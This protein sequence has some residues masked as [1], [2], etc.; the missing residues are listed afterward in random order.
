MTNTVA[1]LLAR[2]PTAPYD[3]VFLDPPYHLD[4]ET[5]AGTCPAEGR[6]WFVPGAM[7]V[8]ERSS[9]GPEPTWPDGF[10]DARERKYGETTLWYGHAA[11]VRPTRG[12]RD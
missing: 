1:A 2:P 12:R 5:L 10:T 9:R 4:D 3:V 11:G 7:L 8:V 6:S